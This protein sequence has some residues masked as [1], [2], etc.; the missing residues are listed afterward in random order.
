MIWIPYAKKLALRD[1]KL[2]MPEA[3]LVP[4]VE[5]T[6]HQDTRELDFQDICKFFATGGGENSDDEA[7]WASLASHQ[8]CRSAASWPEYYQSREKEIMMEIERLIEETIAGEAG[9][10]PRDG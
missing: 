6:I 5:A 10:T 9:G 8:P 2:L 1:A 7:V 3:A 4:G